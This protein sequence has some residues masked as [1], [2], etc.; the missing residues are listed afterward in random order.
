MLKIFNQD[1][2]FPLSVFLNRVKQCCFLEKLKKVCRVFSYF[3][4]LESLVFQKKGTNKWE[5]LVRT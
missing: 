2:F 1:F 3:T 5:Y 4:G